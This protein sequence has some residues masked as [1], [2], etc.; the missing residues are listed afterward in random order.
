MKIRQ[1][2]ID[3][4]K[5]FMKDNRYTIESLSDE[6]DIDLHRNTLSNALAGKNVQFRTIRD[7]ADFMG[8]HVDVLMETKDFTN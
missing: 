3:T 8:I 6:N 4:S 7:I 5:G 1:E 2:G